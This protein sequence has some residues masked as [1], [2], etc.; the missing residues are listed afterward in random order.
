[1]LAQVL[2]GS[3]VDVSGVRAPNL[4]NANDVNNRLLFGA[5]LFGVGW[6]LC[7]L[8][9]GPAIASLALPLVNVGIGSTVLPFIAAMAA[10][11]VVTDQMKW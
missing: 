6:S 7:G 5:A 10:G 1:M 4:P 9:P 3:R 11:M 8:C 2:T